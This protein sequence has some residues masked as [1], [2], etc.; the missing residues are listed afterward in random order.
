VVDWIVKELDEATELV[1]LTRPS[2]EWGRITKGICLGT[3]AEVLLNANSK[4]H[5]PSSDA[6]GKL[7]SYDKNTWQDCADAAKAVI[8]MPQYELQTV[9]TWKDYADIFLHPNPEIIFARVFSIDYAEA[10]YINRVNG[11]LSLGGSGETQALQGLVDAFQMANGKDIHEP[12]SGYDP[13][14][15]TIYNNRDLRFEANINHRGSVWQNYAFQ[16]VLPGGYDVTVKSTTTGY[17]VRKFLDESRAINQPGAM[18]SRLRLATIYLVY[19][20]AQ[21]ELGNED[22]ARKYVNKVRNRVKLPDI[23]SSGDELFKDIQHERRIEL[24]FEGYRFYDVRRWMIAMETENQPAMGIVWKKLDSNGNL[25]P[26]GNLTYT[27]EVFQ[28]RSFSA[29]FYYLPIPK[30]EIVRTNLEQ[31]PD[32]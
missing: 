22:E 10:N 11:P 29:K 9:E 27:F 21:F 18:W 25:D 23:N 24:C 16:L 17:P 6:N 4:L 14:P 26:N 19:A 5:N 7:F 8:D 13:S 31:N 3:K 15:E 32:Y 28:N 30:N 1:P 12:G 20:E 2:N